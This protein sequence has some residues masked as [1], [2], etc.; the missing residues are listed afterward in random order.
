MLEH[1]ECIDAIIVSRRHRPG[2][3]VVDKSFE[4]PA[5]RHPLLHVG[6]ES[7]IEV[8]GGEFR[9]VLSH[10]AGAKGIGTADLKYV[11]ATGKQ[12]GDK[13][14]A[15]Q[16]EGEPLWIVVPSIAS[17][18]A[19]TLEALLLSLFEHALVLWF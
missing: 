14:V 18:K 2:Q 10:D 16:R 9:D 7:G 15:R 19:E 5:R 12:L 13:L 6:D 4:R 1:V 17:H 8:G 11:R 3:H